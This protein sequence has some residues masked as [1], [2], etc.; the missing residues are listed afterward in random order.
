MTAAHALL[1]VG[2]NTAIAE[3]DAIINRRFASKRSIRIVQSPANNWYCAV[4][5]NGES[6]SERGMVFPPCPNLD[7]VIRFVRAFAEKEGVRVD[8][9][10]IEFF[11]AERAGMGFSE[12]VPDNVVPI[13]EDV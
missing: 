10:S 6:S 7:T 12:R 4:I 13:R 8:E 2:F 11:R 9:D 1:S 5:E 3:L